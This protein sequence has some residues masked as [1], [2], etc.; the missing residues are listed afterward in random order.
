[1]SSA[2]PCLHFEVFFCFAEEKVVIDMGAITQRKR[3]VQKFLV[4]NFTTISIL[5]FSFSASLG[6]SRTVYVLLYN[7]GT[8]YEGIHTIKVDETN[9][10]VLM[11][12][13][14]ADAT[15]Y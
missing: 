5:V 1:M 3:W 10:M 7:A 4:L 6:Q 9:N 14:Q 12:E 11:F 8:T 2:Q 13:S 15:R